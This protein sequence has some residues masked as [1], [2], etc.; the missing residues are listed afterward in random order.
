M[1]L[2]CL[3]LGILPIGFNHLDQYINDTSFTFLAKHCQHYDTA[4]PIL[5]SEAIHLLFQGASPLEEDFLFKEDI[6]MLVLSYPDNN[7]HPFYVCHEEII[8]PELTYEGF[9]NMV[10]RIYNI[11]NMEGQQTLPPRTTDHFV[12][13]CETRFEKIKYDDLKYLEVMDDNILVHTTDQTFATVEKL[14]WIMAQLPLN[15]FMQVHRW[16]VVGFRHIDELA[17]DHLY[18][19]PSRIPLAKHISEE[20]ERRYKKR[21]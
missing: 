6:R 9:Y 13:R 17:K 18:I 2:N 7:P 21:W 20:V 3:I 16:F 4:L 1:M 11:I 5:E 14:D 8:F 19:G 10:N 12:L 15:A